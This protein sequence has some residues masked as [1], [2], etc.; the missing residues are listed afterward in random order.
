MYGLG[1][2]VWLWLRLWLWL[3]WL[4][5]WVAVAVAVAASRLPK[6]NLLFFARLTFSSLGKL[7]PKLGLI[8]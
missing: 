6:A 4:W 8:F 2:W 3:L 5:M 7:A 1:L